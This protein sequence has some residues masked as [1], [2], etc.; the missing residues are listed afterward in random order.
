MQN[1]FLDRFVD[2]FPTLLLVSLLILGC[3]LTLLA[4]KKGDKRREKSL[5]AE[6]SD[7]YLKKWLEQDVVYIISPQE[8]AAFNQL[9]TDDERY[10]FVEQF[11]LRR[12]PT[13]DTMINETRDEHYRRIAY[14]NERFPSG[15]PGWK[16]DR[17][18]IYIM[19]G[20]P[21]SIETFHGGDMTLRDFNEGGGWSVKHPHIKWR[22]RHIAGPDLG[23]EVIIEFVDRG[24]SG[25]Y[26]IAR[27]PFEKDALANAPGYD[28]DQNLILANVEPISRNR[29]PGGLDVETFH[30]MQSDK[31]MQT[32]AL[33]Q[34]PKIRFKDLETVV[35]T[36]LSYNLFPFEFK[37]DY[38]KIT[39]DTVL[40]AITVAMKNSDM[41][42]KQQEGVHEASVN[43]FGRITTITGRR[44]HLFEE[45][46]RQMTPDSTYKEAL[47]RT[48]LYQTTVPLSSG[49]YKVELVLKDINSGDVGTIYRSIRVPRF[50]EDQLATSSIILADRIE[51]LPAYQ[52]ASGPFVLGASKVFPNVAETFH[53]ATPM[54][55]YFQVYNLALDEETQKPSATI[56][57]ILKK[58][59]QEIRR[60]REGKDV[61]EGALRQVTLAKLFPLNNLQPGEYSL[62]LN[63]TD[64][65]AN[66]TVSP[67]AKFKVQ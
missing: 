7:R 45:P 30:L 8:K 13:P 67:V 53:R 60:F 55:I 11:W 31:L 62:V 63:I 37:T 25:E 6:T 22:Y 9:Q 47:E 57:Y 14:A 5:R 19:W 36:K 26:R 52:A 56:E 18:R 20:P 10:E 17:G 58:G 24:F 27:D 38:L 32:V 35:D 4:R 29:L 64:N 44:V 59:D 39:D 16:T 23:S 65:L 66:R 43:V 51:P 21:D 2:R 41:T 12:D 46:I 3:S 50:P 49:I 42:F 54:R 15:K 28:I 34:A 33:G 1:R 61:A 48:S 40:T